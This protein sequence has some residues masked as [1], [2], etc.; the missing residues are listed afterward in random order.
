[1]K[2]SCLIVLFTIVLSGCDSNTTVKETAYIE[3]KDKEYVLRDYSEIN[4]AN[5]SFPYIVDIKNA[6]KHIIVYGSHHLFDSQDSIVTDIQK[7]FKELQPDIVFNEGGEWPI[8]HDLE[9]TI[10]K[11]GEMGLIRYLAKQNNIPAYSIEP[12]A[13]EEF[14]LLL[15]RFNKKHILLKYFLYQ[16]AQVEMGQEKSI[17]D[18]EQF[19]SSFIDNLEKEGFPINENEKQLDY[20]LTIYEGFY[21]KEFD[22]TNIDYSKVVY[23][24]NGNILNKI[25]RTSAEYRDQHFM[26]TIEDSLHKYNK[27]FFQVGGWHAFTIEPALKQIINKK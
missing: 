3:N 23:I 26:K 4:A 15:E 16:L 6:S 25:G 12:S 2:L 24:M 22:L 27:I 5:F 21:D 1:M 20:I 9:E 13:E 7:K 19:Y 10:R 17:S 8:Y 14:K 11:S 18:L